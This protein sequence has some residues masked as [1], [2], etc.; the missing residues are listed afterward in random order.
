MSRA[1]A[2]LE[3]LKI[4][5]K[6]RLKTMSKGTKEKVQLI[7]TMSRRAKLYCL[8]E[9]IAGVDPGQHAITF[10][11]TIFKTTTNQT[12]PSSSQHI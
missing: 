7:L 1:N 12:H 3:S 2:M 5:P 10:L 4:S 11:S 8:D 9:P 6:D